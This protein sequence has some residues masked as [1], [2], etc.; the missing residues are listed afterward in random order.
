MP[1]GGATG[2][3]LASVASAEEAAAGVPLAGVCGGSWLA[4]FT[5][6][7]E[8]MRQY[9]LNHGVRCFRGK[10]SLSD[11]PIQAFDLVC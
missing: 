2:A 8:N 10:L 6:Q 11:L 5:D 9:I 3:P 7:W 4:L 1:G